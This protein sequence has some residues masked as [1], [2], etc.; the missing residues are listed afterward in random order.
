MSE[1]E[2]ACRAGA[3]ALRERADQLREQLPDREPLPP[4]VQQLLDDAAT[5]EQ[6]A[7]DSSLLDQ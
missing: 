5:L 1:L 7:E 2:Q 4:N 6:L 3:Q